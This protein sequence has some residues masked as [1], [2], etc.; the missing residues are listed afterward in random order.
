MTSL[1]FPP[2]DV[3]LIPLGI[4]HK[5][6]TMEIREPEILKAP[7]IKLEEL[8]NLPRVVAVAFIM[9][10]ECLHEVITVEHYSTL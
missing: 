4:I 1:R 8:D 2:G 10:V 6:K 7:A 5:Q 3:N 9:L